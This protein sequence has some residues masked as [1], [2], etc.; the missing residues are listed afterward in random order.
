MGVAELRPEERDGAVALALNPVSPSLCLEALRLGGSA[1]TTARIADLL[2]YED[3]LR[4][5]HRSVEIK[6]AAARALARTGDGAAQQLLVTMLDDAEG[7]VVK[8]A[9]EALGVVGTLSAIEP[10]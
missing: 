2:S 6:E 10:L 8:S 4:T 5:G 3:V 9:I 7:R 1:L